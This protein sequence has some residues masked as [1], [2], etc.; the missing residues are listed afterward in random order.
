MSDDPP[1]AVTFFKNFAAQTKREKPCTLFALAARIYSVTAEAKTKLPWLKL[2]RFGDNRS[3]KNSLRHDANVLAI[4]GIEADYDAGG[5]AFDAAVELLRKAGIR[6]IVYTSPSYTPGFPK[7]RVLCPFSEELPPH[8]RARMLGRLAG[9]FAD[10][11]V[12]FAA[13]SWALSQSYY[14]GSVNGNPA[15]Q[16]DLIDGTPIDLH[17]DLDRIWKGKPGTREGTGK[18]NGEYRS[19]LAD[20]PSLREAIV[21]G[22][23][24][25]PAAVRLTGKWAQQ[26]V[27]LMAAQARLHAL[28]DAVPEP[29]RDQRWKQRRGDVPR[30]VLDIYGKDAGKA[31][32]GPGAA[33]HGDGKA[34]GNR[35]AVWPEPL[36]CFT[37]ANTEPAEATEDEV[38]PAL[39]PFVDDTA[40][41]MGVARSTVALCCLVPC[42][43]VITDDWY[44][45]PK[46]LDT[47]WTECARIWG[48]VVGPP[49]IMKS[50]VIAACT[51]P[52]DHMERQTR[53]Q[54]EAD[55]RHWR[56][57]EKAAK[58]ERRDHTDSKPKRPRWLVES[59][60][61]EA[62]QEVLR[63][64][65]DAR[66]EAPARKVLVRQDELGEFLAN[67]DRYSTGRGGGDR[68]AY[69]RLYNGGPFSVDRIG[70][71][72]FTSGNWSGCLLGGI[73]PEPIQR[74][75]QHAVDDGLLQRFLYDVPAGM[76]EAGED[77]P[78]GEAAVTRYH[79][80]IP[81]L[82]ALH[83]PRGPVQPVVLHADAHIYREDINALA[84][85]MARLPDVSPRLQATFG[86]WP[87]LFARLCLTFHLIEVAD[88]RAERNVGPYVGVVTAAS[89][90]QVA[91]YMRRVLLSHLLR[92]DAVMFNTVQTGH[93]KWIAGH[94]L[95][96]R[97]DRIAV[98]D[99]V[100][101]YKALRAPE[102]RGELESV[103]ASLAAADWLD[104]ELPRNPFKPV[105]AWRVN[106]RVHALFAERAEQ[107]RQERRERQE[108]TI[109][110]KQAWLAAR[111]AGGGG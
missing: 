62:L 59:A 57:Q 2:A 110:R 43:A 49:S 20:E 108:E 28:F 70:R 9:L 51:R 56:E 32:H 38:P 84:R 61:I 65:E 85:D 100:Q 78:P 75:A 96:H 41:R 3:D 106:P 82:T 5:V 17:D 53:E 26:G 76:E 33:E 14:Y 90:A 37:A 15:H 93:A 92:A 50:P 69:L 63:E 48:A 73:Q 12:E 64:D 54:W 95:A 36:N 77:R 72:A 71:G 99:V 74:I 39:W 34:T 19:G 98:R 55:L 60:T 103:M 1:V 83:P 68:G 101:S 109:R 10:I 30:I 91:G 21:N 25:H 13:E 22:T 35:A 81:A 52:L 47:T 11:G 88:A 42:S 86:K 31:D 66:F 18:P 46:R 102:M 44:I 79:R 111:A 104:P 8:Q 23:N 45:Q 7:W 94:I 105:I 4:S 6:S 107:E 29:A 58:D 87:G 16:V 24:Y 40:K 80:L 67:L 27:S 89:A 97:L